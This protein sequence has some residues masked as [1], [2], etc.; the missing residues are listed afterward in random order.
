MAK[1]GSVTLTTPLLPAKLCPSFT[2]PQ[3]QTSHPSTIWT[4]HIGGVSPVRRKRLFLSCLY[5]RCFRSWEVVCLHGHFR[6]HV[7]GG[8]SDATQQIVG[9]GPR[10][11]SFASSVVR[12]S[13]SVA[14]WPGQLRRWASVVRKRDWY[15]TSTPLV[16]INL[17]RRLRECISTNK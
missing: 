3:T 16:G 11:A 14:P 2:I 10:A 8:F 5:C 7:A 13:C 15:E 6:M 1:A 12:R 17:Y 4:T 9:P